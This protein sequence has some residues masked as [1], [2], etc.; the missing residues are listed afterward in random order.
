MSR[1]KPIGVC[2]PRLMSGRRRRALLYAI[3]GPLAVIEALDDAQYFGSYA[4]M[5]RPSG[6]RIWPPVQTLAAG[7][8]ALRALESLADW[9]LDKEALRGI[10]GLGDKA[11]AAIERA[12]ASPPR[13]TDHGGEG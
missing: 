4:I 12:D 6:T 10:A 9:S 13:P 2:Y 7:R 1:A 5:H 8:R 3:R 11:R